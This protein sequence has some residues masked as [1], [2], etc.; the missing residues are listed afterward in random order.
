MVKLSACHN[1]HENWEDTI[2]YLDMLEGIVVFPEDSLNYG[3]F[4]KKWNLLDI[5]EYSSKRELCIVGSHNQKVLVIQDGKI[6]KYD[7]YAPP[8]TLNSD[9]CDVS[10]LVRICAGSQYRQED[11]FIESKQRAE[12]MI[13]SS[14]IPFPAEIITGIHSGSLS[15]NPYFILACYEIDNCA[16][17]DKNGKNLSKLIKSPAGNYLTVDINKR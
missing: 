11:D 4:K 9:G 1:L 7:E 17:T 13:V 6:N 14:A 12:L 16:I 3:V 15:D 8:I 2:K 5:V 10:A